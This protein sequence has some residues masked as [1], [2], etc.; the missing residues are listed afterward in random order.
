MIPKG[1]RIEH[2]RL[3]QLLLCPLAQDDQGTRE[4]GRI[5]LLPQ[6]G[7]Q[8]KFRRDDIFV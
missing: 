7:W 6:V 8:I 5:V 3:T 2:D 4:I 1:S